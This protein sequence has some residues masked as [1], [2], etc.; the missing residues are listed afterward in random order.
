MSHKDTSKYSK[1]TNHSVLPCQRSHRRQDS[2][3]G[4][5]CG[6]YARCESRERPPSYP[7][8]ARSGIESQEESGR[9]LKEKMELRKL[10]RDQ[11]ILRTSFNRGH[12]CPYLERELVLLTAPNLKTRVVSTELPEPLGTDCE[13]STGHDGAPA[14]YGSIH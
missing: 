10:L 12:D 4:Q 3:K 5:I 7:H 1:R 14:K 6:I 13:Q 2:E 9:H 8:T 11:R